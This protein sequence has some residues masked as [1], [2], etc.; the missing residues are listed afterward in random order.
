MINRTLSSVS[1]CRCSIE[2][3]L[4]KNLKA[5]VVRVGTKKLSENGFTYVSRDNINN[6]D[7]VGESFILSQRIVAGAQDGEEIQIVSVPLPLHVLRIFNM[8][9]KR[10]HHADLCYKTTIRDCR[11]FQSLFQIAT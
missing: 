4:I 7:P 10:L 8:Q 6:F 9:L 3:A 5:K 11:P 1:W 2:A